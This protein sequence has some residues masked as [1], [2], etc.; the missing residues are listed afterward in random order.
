VNGID[1]DASGPTDVDDLEIAPL[2]ELVDRAATNAE[3]SPGAFDRE[4][5]HELPFV[6]RAHLGGDW[7]ES[8]Q[9]LRG[10]LRS[11]AGR[12]RGLGAGFVFAPQTDTSGRGAV[13]VR[14]SPP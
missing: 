1:R 12:A 9:L 8:R 3:C 10:A 13:I 7:C 14:V 5:E 2:D 11:V 6:A 4:Q